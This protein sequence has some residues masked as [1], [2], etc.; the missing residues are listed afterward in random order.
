MRVI[1]IAVF[2]TNEQWEVVPMSSG[3]GMDYDS[4]YCT[5]YMLQYI[6]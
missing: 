1:E 3:I 4:D 5:C 6:A 2:E